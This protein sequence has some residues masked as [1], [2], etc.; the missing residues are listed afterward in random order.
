MKSLPIPTLPWSIV[1]SDLFEWE[2]NDYLVLVDSY[3][4]WWE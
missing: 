4:G 2:G 1:A 3:S